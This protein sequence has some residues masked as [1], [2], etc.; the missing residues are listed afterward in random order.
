MT[1]NFTRTLGKGGFATVYHGVLDNGTEVAVKKIRIETGKGSQVQSQN[2]NRRKTDE[3]E[4]QYQ[5]F[6]AEASVSNSYA[7]NLKF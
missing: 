7:N 5:H 6:Q 2:S 3:G 1:D 4:E